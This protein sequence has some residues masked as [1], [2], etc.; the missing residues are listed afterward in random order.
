[1]KVVNRR[2]FINW[3]KYNCQDDDSSYVEQT[4]RKLKTRIKEHKADINKLSNLLSVIC[5]ILLSINKD[6][7]LDWNILSL[8]RTIILQKN[9]FWDDTH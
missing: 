2:S 1:M 7:A 6:H 3:G 8:K 4:K 5:Y 9:N